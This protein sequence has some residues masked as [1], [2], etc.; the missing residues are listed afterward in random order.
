MEREKREERIGNTVER[1]I[2]QIR[3][4]DERKT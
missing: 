2:S 4:R 1:F 3:L